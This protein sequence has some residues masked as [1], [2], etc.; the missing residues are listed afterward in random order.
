MLILRSSLVVAAVVAGAQCVAEVRLSNHPNGCVVVGDTYRLVVDVTQ[1]PVARLLS[2]DGKTEL[3]RLRNVW[4]SEGKRLYASRPA[5]GPPVFHPLRSGP[6]LVEL[7]IENIALRSEEDEAAWPGLAELSLFCHIDRVYVLAAF[8][9]PKREWVNRGQYV[10]RAPEGHRACPA[11][12]P[13]ECGFSLGL[14]ASASPLALPEGIIVPGPSPIAL[15]PSVPSP[16]CKAVVGVSDVAFSLAPEDLPWQPG[17]SHE[18]GAMV[19]IHNSVDAVRAA[20]TH[21][22]RPLG[23]DAFAMTMGQAPGF[24]PARGVYRL[25]AQTSGTPTPPRGLRAGAKY[26]VANDGLRRRILV[27]QLDPWGGITSGIVRDGAGKPLPILI[28]FG[29]NFPE[30][31]KAAGEPGWA[32]LTYP[33]ELSPNQTREINAEHIYHA[34]SDREAIYLTSLENI[35]SPLLLQTTVGRTEAHTLT[36][37]AYPGE[38]TSGN[39]LRVNDFR[40]IHSRQVSRSVSAIL[41]TFFGYWDARDTYQGLMPGFVSFRETSPF[42]IEYAVDASTRDG[43]VTGSVRVWQTAHEDMT[44][45][46]TDVSLNVTKPIRLSPEREAPLFFLRH[47]AFNPMAFSKFAFTGEDDQ[48]RTGDLGYARSVVTNRAPMGSKPFA[49]VYRAGNV[50]EQG[51]PCSDITGNSGFVVLDWDVRLGGGPARPGCYAFCT[52]A[53]DTEDGAY[54][55]DV[56]IVPVEDVRQIAAGSRIR[57]RAVQMVWGNNSSDYTTME[58]ERRRWA[59]RPLTLRALVGEVVSSDP[60]E[61]AAKDGRAT[62]EIRGGTDWVP[63]RVRG[64][65]PTRPPHVRQIDTNGARELGP[66]APGEPWYNAWPT[67][68]PGCGFTFLI[69]ASGDGGPIR[70]QVWQ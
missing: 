4:L 63:L 62:L 44:R 7:H 25:R 5:A 11:V 22:A 55:R 17:S 48:A 42:L 35:G 64:L 51:I 70:L 20:L 29:L 59:L 40:R 18:T 28:Q 39:E 2:T 24:D 15:R 12:S 8:V 61:A 6:Y 60:P 47:H 41:P 9:C 14:P 21:E 34:L 13:S 3:A 57:Y 31:H 56:A 36:T 27:D 23:A 33:L 10:Y 54:A 49:C 58:R 38:L 65:D 45:I 1:D 43:A 52:G 69:K 53:G 37:G 30:H 19:V 16:G 26:A 68:E 50:L 66:G 46:F 67:D 32:T